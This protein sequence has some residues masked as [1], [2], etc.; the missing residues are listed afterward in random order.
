[1]S[2]GGYAASGVVGG[3]P[4]ASATV[5]WNSGTVGGGEAVGFDV[6]DFTSSGDVG[7][8]DPFGGVSALAPNGTVGGS[9]SPEPTVLTQVPGAVRTIGSATGVRAAGPSG[10]I[11][12]MSMPGIAGAGF[13]AGSDDTSAGGAGDDASTAPA[14][15]AAP[16]GGG[17]TKA[18]GRGGTK[19]GGPKGGTKGAGTKGGTKSGGSKGASGSVTVRK[20]DSLAS[21]AKAHHTTVHAIVARNPGSLSAK[22]HHVKPGQKLKMP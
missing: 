12:G 1:M 2:D 13:A 21:I 22:D 7:G 4:L 15:H 14:G 5:I 20:G 19:S 6:P 17:G 8:G 9:W 18:G 11:A 10:S 3:G 16:A